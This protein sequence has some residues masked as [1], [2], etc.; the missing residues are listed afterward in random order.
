MIRWLALLLLWP[1]TLLADPFPAL[2]DVTGVAND[3][4][5]NIREEPSVNTPV[6]AELAFNA[7][8]IEVVGLS[9]DARWG[10]VNAM[11]TSGW[12]ALRYLMPVPGDHWAH[13]GA[14]LR[15]G[16]TEP[17][18]NFSV[19]D[20]TSGQAVFEALALDE[21]LT[22]SIKWQ[23]GQTARP[24]LAI[25]LGGS[26]PEGNF[27]AVIRRE[28]C[29]DGMSDRN[30]GLDIDLFFHNGGEASGYEGCCSVVP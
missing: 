13:P 8:N 7:R 4:V 24:D 25:G 16:G 28:A 18:W 14:K 23:S 26:G 19:N 29:H 11:E 1:V 15:C 9:E 6:I 2:Y 27:S 30:F 3:D 21:T 12:V 17:F 5:L 20:N 10:L 22:Y